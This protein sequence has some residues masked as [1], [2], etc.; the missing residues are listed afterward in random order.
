MGGP[1]IAARALGFRSARRALVLAPQLVLALILTSGLGACSRD[2]SVLTFATTTS[3]QDS[4][5]LA[6]LSKAFEQEHPRISLKIVTA[7]SGEILELGKGADADALLVHSPAAE[8]AFMKNGYGLSRKPVM[9]NEF[10]IAGPA[11]DPAGVGS[12]TTAPDAFRLIASTS[13]TFVSRGDGSG[14]HKKESDIWRDSGAEHSGNW[15]LESGQGQAETIALAAEKHAYLLTDSSTF[16]AVPH[17]GLV[18][19]FEGN[20]NLVNHYS[21]IVVRRAVNLKDAEELSR[22]L[23]SSSGQNV[24]ADFGKR[25]FGH[26]SFEPEGQSGGQPE[27][28]H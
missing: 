17:P 24:I 22:W 4:G 14:T 23:T 15:Y 10:L 3:V 12:A 11:A 5:I 7:G 18:T 6:V 8:L 20:A 25:R 19:L 9:R 27:M 16:I 1:R 21:V 13:S 28:S 26:S 2:R